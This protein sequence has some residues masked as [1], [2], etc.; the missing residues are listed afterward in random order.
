MAHRTQ[1][2]TATKLM[3]LSKVSK[4]SPKYKFGSLASL[5]NEEYLRT[6]YAELPR[7]K[8]LG[9]RSECRRIRRIA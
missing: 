4:D 1:S 2:D 3:Q 8:A 9:R 6:C 7:K 5:L